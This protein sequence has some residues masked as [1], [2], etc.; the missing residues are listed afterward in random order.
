MCKKCCNGSK[1]IHIFNVITYHYITLNNRFLLKLWLWG[2]NCITSIFLLYI[3]HD[4]FIWA[5]KCSDKKFV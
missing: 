3:L 1:T 5:Q 4:N 2:S